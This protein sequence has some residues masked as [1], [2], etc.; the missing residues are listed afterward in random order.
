MCAVKYDSSHPVRDA[1][2]K[3]LKSK[4]K[5]RFLWQ[6]WPPGGLSAAIQGN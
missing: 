5:F 2:R 4:K 3:V 1:K 6:P